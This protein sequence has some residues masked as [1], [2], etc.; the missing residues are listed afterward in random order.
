MEYLWQILSDVSGL[1]LSAK[2]EVDAFS[3][4]SIFW[5]GN[6]TWGTH[7]AQTFLNLLCFRY[8]SESRFLFGALHRRSKLAN[9]CHDLMQNYLS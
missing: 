5:A 6:N 2:P 9:F 7:R 3:T 1:Y 4:Q 8:I